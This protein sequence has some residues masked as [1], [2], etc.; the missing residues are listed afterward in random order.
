VIIAIVSALADPLAEPGRADAGGRNVYVGA[1][2]RALAALGNRVVAYTRRAGPARP[3]RSAL[4]PQCEL[5]DIDAGPS[6][7]LGEAHADAFATELRRHW[8]SDPPDVV[9]AQGW[10]SA[11]AALTAAKPLGIPVVVT[12][13]GRGAGQRRRDEAA[14]VRA[15]DRIIATSSADVFT[16]MQLGATPRAVKI[17]PCG[18]DVAAF[19]PDGD[20]VPRGPRLRL[21]AIGRLAPRTGIA[22]TIAALAAT[23]N[24]ELVVAGGSDDVHSDPDAQRLRDIARSCGVAERVTLLGRL[25]HGAVPAFL[26]SADVVVCVPWDQPFG[27]AVLEAMACGKPVVV[28]HVGGLVDLVAD[29]LTGIHVPPCDP[30]R[31]AEALATL[32]GDAAKVLRL[33]RFAAE[34]AARYAWP[35]IAAETLAVYRSAG[36]QRPGVRAMVPG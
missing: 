10:T 20:S 31:L 21:A 9:H 34:R 23:G 17:V 13:D 28:S 7:P 4:A 22:D 5:V 2:A 8:A 1:L 33:G 32:A 27:M 35:R 3:A 12:F 36:E 29:G 16:L 11:R 26:R 14:I 15:A 24:A 30:R 18:V 25:P 6:G 19:A